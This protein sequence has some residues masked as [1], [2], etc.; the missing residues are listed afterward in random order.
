MHAL[1]VVFVLVITHVL[2]LLARTQ[3]PVGD[4]QFLRSMI[5]HHSSAILCVSKR[6][7]PTLRLKR[8]DHRV[9]ARGDPA[10]GPTRT[11]SDGLRLIFKGMVLTLR[12]KKRRR[13]RTGSDGCADSAERAP[14]ALSAWA[15]HDR[16]AILH[17]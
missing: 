9:A 2:L 13:L 15:A 3:T 14:L 16:P 12:L 5:P 17:R 1:S 8:P 7:F 10:A 4:D 6:P 11:T